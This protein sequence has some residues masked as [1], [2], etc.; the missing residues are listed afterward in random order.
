M[1]VVVLTRNAGDL[2]TE[3]LAGV[4]RQTLRAGRYLVIDSS[5]HDATAALAAAAGFDV[6]GIDPRHFN[7][8]GT[9]QLAVQLCPDA[10]YVV[11]LTQDAILEQ[12]DS[13]QTLLAQFE[14]EA[15]AMAYGRHI[16]HQQADLLEKHARG[17]TYPQQPA[18]RTRADFVH[19]GFRAAFYSDVYACYRVA[20]LRS[21]G[22]FPEHVIVSED[23]YVSACLLLSGWKTVYSAHSEVRHSH[24][25]SLWQVFRRYFDVG[26]F[27]AE[28]A[29]LLERIGKPDKE[30]GVYVRSLI[31]YLRERRKRLLPLAALQTLSKLL[32]FRLGKAYRRLPRRLCQLLSMQKAY[33]HTGNVPT[34]GWL[35][36]EDRRLLA[37]VSGSHLPGAFL[38]ATEQRS[39]KRYASAVSSL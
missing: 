11:F 8:G 6:Y 21:I 24:H 12:K 39:L 19:L 25:F 23:S 20:A 1:A 5:S 28:E 9:R 7:H 36:I 17:F 26:V 22:G 37:Q 35:A 15:V 3:W 38:K 13:L 10:D 27:H 33:W 2:W 16:P 29:A 34:P 32:G 14:D 18:T 4:R 31:N 30:A